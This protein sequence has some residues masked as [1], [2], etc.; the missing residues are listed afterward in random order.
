MYDND[1]QAALN[2][3]IRGLARDLEA[4]GILVV[5][6]NPGWVSTNCGGPN[7][8]LSPQKSV[9]GMLETIG[10]LNRTNQGLHLSFNGQNIPW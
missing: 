4:D 6:M 9:E 8:P 5:A 3:T 7:A 10:G 2:M 1:F